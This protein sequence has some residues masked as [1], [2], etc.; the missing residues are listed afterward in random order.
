MA[1]KFSA[2]LKG[3]PSWPFEHFARTMTE[4]LFSED[5][6]IEIIR[7]LGTLETSK[8]TDVLNQQKL[9]SE[10]LQIANTALDLCR[11]TSSL[12]PDQ[13]NKNGLGIETGGGE[14]STPVPTSAPAP[15]VA[16]HDVVAIS[17]KQLSSL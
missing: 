17:N 4:R 7:H 12:S 2:F 5:L 9:F 14:T 1:L 16:Q 8:E 10:I 6:K 15:M 11:R 3:F 13:M